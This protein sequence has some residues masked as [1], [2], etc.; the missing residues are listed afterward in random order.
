[1]GDMGNVRIR[2]IGRGISVDM[3]YRH[4]AIRA[5]GKEM[6][7]IYRFSPDDVSARFTLRASYSHKVSERDYRATTIRRDDKGNL[8]IDAVCVNRLTGKDY[9][10]ASRYVWFT[11]EH[12][13]DK[14]N[15]GAAIAAYVR[16]IAKPL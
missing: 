15:G 10:T 9:Q 7:I 4:S 8:S 3:V 2:P 1:M 12:T 5:V 11:L 13:L 14:F 6:S 16:E